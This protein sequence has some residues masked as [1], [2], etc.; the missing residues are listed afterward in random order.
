MIES[1]GRVMT[2]LG[3]EELIEGVKN[4]AEVMEKSE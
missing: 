1:S 3:W 4:V 2:R